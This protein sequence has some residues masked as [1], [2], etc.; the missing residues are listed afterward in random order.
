MGLIYSQMKGDGK[1]RF[2]GPKTEAAKEVG[3]T[4]LLAVGMNFTRF[5]LFSKMWH[6]ICV[7]CT[8]TRRKTASFYNLWNCSWCCKPQVSKKNLLLFSFNQMYWTWKKVRRISCRIGKEWTQHNDGCY[9]DGVHYRSNGCKE[10]DK[11]S[12]SWN[13]QTNRLHSSLRHLCW[14]PYFFSGSIFRIWWAE[15]TVGQQVNKEQRVGYL[16]F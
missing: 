11:E 1:G 6:S 12:R 9:G 7:G 15:K 14:L 13:W 4:T 2:N 5:A 16:G 3:K 10:V 8:R